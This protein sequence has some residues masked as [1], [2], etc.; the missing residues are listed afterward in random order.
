MKTL[1][2]CPNGYKYYKSSNCPTCPQCEKAHIPSADFLAIVS[3]P[4]RRAL[5]NAGITTFE[6]LAAKTKEEL[7]SLHGL[8]P[9]S[10]PKLIAILEEHG[11]QLRG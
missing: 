9:S 4:A 5:E 2:T 7:L 10:I 8:G 3:A 11:L 1:R 6:K